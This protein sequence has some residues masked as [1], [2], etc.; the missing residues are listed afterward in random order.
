MVEITAKVSTAKAPRG[1]AIQEQSPKIKTGRAKSAPIT[2]TSVIVSLCPPDPASRSPSPSR[3]YASPAPK[4]KKTPRT[5]TFTEASALPVRASSEQPATAKKVAQNQRL[6]S[7]SP[8]TNAP[9]IPAIAGEEP[10]AIIVPI[11]TPVRRT[12]E[13]KENW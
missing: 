8:K 10:M 6:E 7:L 12:P 5:L 3:A 1:T 9:I 11:A 2:E 4:D 13:K